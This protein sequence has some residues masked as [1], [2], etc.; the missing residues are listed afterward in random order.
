MAVSFALN[1][2]DG[3]S[4]ETRARVLRIADELGWRPNSA[5]RALSG[6]RAG[7]FGLVL[8]KRADELAADTFYMQLLAGLESALAPSG[9]SIAMHI[10]ESD[11]AASEIYRSLAAARRVDGF[12]VTDVLVDDPRLPLLAE[13][14]VPAVL[15]GESRPGFAAIE[16][17]DAEGVEQILT[18]LEL[19][20]HRRIG[21]VSGSRRLQYVVRREA[22]Y[23]SGAERRGMSIVTAVAEDSF[24]GAAWATAELLDGPET[25]TALVF[26][27]D[28]FAVAGLGVVRERGLDVPHDISVVTWD[29]SILSAVTRPVLTSLRRDVVELGR[30]AAR[31]LLLG[32]E[33]DAPLAG[34]GGGSVLEADGLTLHLT[35][36]GSTAALEN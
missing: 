13:L 15:L 31:A 12:L 10:A 35:P 22:A 32:L 30:A 16:G 21:R 2:R 23:A 18:H 24:A 9:T 5:A 8:V 7:A 19:L 36:G 17:D 27:T 14:R 3:V 28:L 33:P 20:G 6:D 34:E 1:G 26:D 11:D 25:P 4:A 29:G